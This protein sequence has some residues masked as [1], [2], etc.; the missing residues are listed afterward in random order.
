MTGKPFLDTNVLV[1]ALVVRASSPSDPR[2]EIAERALTQ[3]GVV[4]V[5]ILN[6]FTDVASHK[7]KMSWDSIEEALAAITLLCGRPIPITAEIH[8]SAVG[9]SK[10]CGFRIY[11]SLIVVAAQ[12]AGCDVLYTEDLQHGQVIEGLRIENPFVERK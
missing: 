10:R 11:D 12:E 5:Q 2:A 1:Y 3:G 8:Q 4:S 6:E 7:L 9:L